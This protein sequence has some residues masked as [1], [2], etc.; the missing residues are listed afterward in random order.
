MRVSSRLLLTET[1][2]L[3]MKS[4]PEEAMPHLLLSSMLLKEL[5]QQMLVLRRLLLRKQELSICSLALMKSPESSSR[6]REVTFL[7]LLNSMSKSVELS[8]RRLPMLRNLP[9]TV[10]I[11]RELGI[12]S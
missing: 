2:L 3:S 6:Q 1:K 5:E 7:F 12:L 11:R 8:L 9:L 4:E 10:S